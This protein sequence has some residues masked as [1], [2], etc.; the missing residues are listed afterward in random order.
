M[1]FTKQRQSLG[2]LDYQSPMQ[3]GKP[4]KLH[5]VTLAVKKRLSAKIL[6]DN[7]GVKIVWCKGKQLFQ[8][9]G[10][11]F[12]PNEWANMKFQWPGVF[13]KSLK[14]AVD[15]EFDGENSLVNFGRN[16]E[17]KLRKLITDGI[18][19][20]LQP[21]MFPRQSGS[22]GQKHLIKGENTKKSWWKYS[23]R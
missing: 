19:R 12:C 20:A 3:R 16:W 10:F 11:I 4:K 23:P 21:I 22:F 2:F 13:Y 17:Q 15:R 7:S 8:L 9:V 14:N 5:Q 18:F 6:L 1:W